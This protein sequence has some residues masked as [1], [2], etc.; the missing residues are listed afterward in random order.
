MARS[1]H[2]RDP[3]PVR[4]IPPVADLDPRLARVR[5]LAWIMDKSIPIGGGQRIGLDPLL[6]L[7]PGAGDAIGAIISL[8]VVYESARLGLPVRVLGRMVGNI[9][10]EAVVGTVPLFGDV[11]DAFWKAN[12]R[13]AQLLDR[14][15][16]PER[17]DRPLG[18]IV[19][20]LVFIAVFLV[21]LT[22]TAAFLAI[23]ALWELF[24][25]INA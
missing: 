22:L 10:I 16:Q 8:F 6:G 15:Y 13:N 2:S 12:A 20:G 23:R 14:H 3:Q 21:A 18:R 17:P 7:W 4:V 24:S 25:Q 19:L 11:F 9:L 5:R 1:S